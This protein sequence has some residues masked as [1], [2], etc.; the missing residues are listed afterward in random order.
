MVTD[1]FSKSSLDL[2]GKVTLSQPTSLDWGPD[3][4]LYVTEVTGS[5][6]VLTVAFGDVDPNDGEN[7][8]SFYVTEAETLSQ[9]KDI[10]N[11][12]DDG[13]PNTGNNRQVTG[14]SVVQQ[15]AADGTPVIIDGKPAVSVYVTS[16][17]SRMGAGGDG[18]DSGLD[19][20]S[21][22]IT[23]IDQ[24]ETGWE[25]IDLVRGLARS[26]ENH[27]LNGLEVVQEVDENGNLVS[28]RMIV[29]SGGNA[30]SGAPSNNFAGQ[31]ETAYSAAILEVDLDQ[32]NGMPVLT[33][34]SSGRQY[35]YD[36]PTLDD[37]TRP[38]NP[39]EN[40]PFGGNDSLNA[41][42]IDP[43]GPVQIY[44]A[45]YRNSYDVEVTE[46]GRVWTYDNGANDS[47]GGR[48][49]GEAGDDGGNQDFAQLANYIA[50]NL[51]NGDI[52]TGDP[53]N[54]E[55]WSPKN[56]DQFHEIT[57][58]DDLSGRE[59]S[60][61]QGGAQTYQWQDPDSGETL[62]LVYGGHPNPTRASG[63]QSGML[64]TPKDGVEDAYLLLS[65][66]VDP[67]TGTSDFDD[68]F[69]WMEQVEIDY[70]TVDTG[71]LTSRLIGVTPGEHY[72]ITD[73]GNAYLTSNY[74]EQPTEINGE[75][76]LGDSGMPIDFHE[77]VATL[78]PI[79]G[80]Y[81]EG[82]YTDGA[83]DSGKGSINGLTEYT[84]TILDDPDSGVKMSGAILA[85]VLNQGSLVAMGRDENGVMQTSVGGS[86]QTL[87]D[88]RTIIDVNGAPLGLTSI[89]D[90]L[91][92]HGGE[93]AF[94]GSI[95]TTVFKQNGPFIEILQPNNGAVPLAGSEAS[96]P[97]DQDMDGI[98]HI[99]D[100]FEF[101]EDNGFDLAAGERVF[102][103]FQPTGSPY[104]G[105]ILDTG[106]MGAALDGM[107]PNR[108]A[109]TAEEGFSEDQQEDG[110]YDLGGNIIP[111]GNAPI[112]QIKKVVGGSVVGTG[113]TARDAMHVGIK[114]A[115][116]VERLVMSSK[117]K[118]WVPSVT[119]GIKQG[120]LTGIMLGDGTQANFLRFMFGA[121]MVNGSL[122]PGFE[123]GYELDDANYTTLATVGVP[124]LN[125]TDVSLLDLNLE[126]DIENGFAVKASYQLDTQSQATELDLGGFSL[127]PGVL[128]DILT[129]NHTITD[130][131]ITV[132]SGA[133]V[134][135]LAETTPEDAASEDGLSGVDFFN[136]N[137]EAIGNEI[138]ATTGEEVGAE[139]TDGIDTILYTGTDTNLAPLDQSVENFDGSG[140]SADFHVTGHGGDNIFIAG[141]G[142][143]TFTGG[144]GADSIRG[145]FE[146]IDGS[147]ITDF[148]QDDHLLI[149]ESFLSANDVSYSSSGGALILTFTDSNTGE[150][151]SVSFTGPQF[152][153]F[154]PNEGPSVF[155][156]EQT[157]FGTQVT[158]SLETVVYRVNAGGGTVAAL[159][160]DLDW[161]GDTNS[162][163]AYLQG[164][165]T[166]TYSDSLTDE[167]T[168][169]DLTQFD[170]DVVPW[171]VFAQERY[172]GS[173]AEP[174]IEYAF[175]VIAGET[176]SVTLYYTENWSGIFN[177]TG[178]RIFDVEVE[179][180]VPGVFND[181]NPLQEAKDI[182]GPD[183]TNAELL[184]FGL[185]RTY[186]FTA[187]DDTLNLA[188]N[189]GDQNPKINAIEINQI[190]AD[191]GV[192]DSESPVVQSITV[193]DPL[194]NDSPILATVVI[195]DNVEVDIGTVEGDELIITGIEPAT[196]SLSSIVVSNGGKTATVQYQ[197]TP[198]SD[199][200]AWESGTYSVGVAE[201][202]YLD[203]SGNGVAAFETDFTIGDEGGIATLFELDFETAGEPLDEGGFDDVLGGVNDGSVVTTIE[204][205]DLVVNTSDG[206][207]I[208][209][210]SANDFVKFVDLSD[211]SLNELTISSRF[212]NGFPAALTD[213][214]LSP[215]TIPNYAQQGIVFGLGSQG[216]N[217]LVKLVLSGNSGNIVQIWSNPD[218][219]GGIDT[220]YALG[221]MLNDTSL[222]LQDIAEVE[223]SMVIDKAAGT[224]TPIV[225]LYADS[226]AVLG[227]LRATA[228]PGFVTAQAETLPTPVLDNLLDAAANTAVGVTSNDFG[229]LDSFEARWADLRVTSP[230]GASEDAT[231][232]GIDDAP[233]V[234]ESGDSG[235]TTLAFAL[236]A[237]NTVDTTLDILYSVDGGTTQTQAVAFSGNVGMLAIEVP[238]DDV[239][240]GPDT[241]EVSLVGVND[242]QY[243]I[244]P[245]ATTASGTVAEDDAP[246]SDVIGESGVTSLTQAS[247]GDWTSV[248]FS[249]ALVNPAVVMGPLTTNDGE[250]ATVRVRNVTDS[251][252]EF[253]IDEWDYLDGVHGQETISWLAINSGTHTLPNGQTIAA[254]KGAADGTATAFTYGTAFAEAPVVLAQATSTNG[255]ASVT[256]RIDGVTAS[257]FNLRLQHEEGASSAPASEAVDW[258]AVSA[259]GG[260]AGGLLA[261]RTGDQ[262]THQD[263]AIDFGGSFAELAFFA[264]MQTFDGPDSATVRAR[265]IGAEGAT[266]FVEEEQSADSELTH[267][268]EDVG[269]VG[270]NA[271]VITGSEGVSTPTLIGIDDAPTVTESGDSGTTTLAFALTAEDTVDATLD[272]LYSVDGGA[273]QTQAVTFS[274]NVGTLAIEVPNDDVDNGP[275]TVEVSLVGVNDD[276]YAIDPAAT[277]ASGTVAEDDAPASDVIGESGVT[278]LTQASSGDWTSVTFSEALVNPAVVMGPLTTNDG[279]PATV[280]VRNVTDS[281]FEF[282]I[283]EWDYLDGVHGQETISWLAINS[284]THTL[285]SGQTIAAGKGAADGTATAF[286]Y[287]TAFAEAPVVLAQ[288]TSTNGSAA[289][290]DRID[291]VTT[292]GFNLRLQHEE[293]ASSA[294]VSEAVDWIA[295]SEGG[296]TAGGLLAGRTGDQVTHQD[297]AIDFGGS[298]AEL[299]FF[300]DMQTFDGP[301]SAT[302]RARAIG[303]EGATIFVE[304]EQSAD[305]ELTHTHEDVGYVGLNAGVITGSEG[306]STPTLIGIDD[307][308]TVTESGD[309]GTT[310]L[311]FALTAEDTVDATLDIVY[312]VD[313]GAT[314]QTQV[315]AFSGNVGT[316]QVNV[317]NDDIDNGPD[318]V[319]VTLVGINDVQYDSDPAADT[320]SGSVSED[321]GPAPLTAEQVFAG[322][323]LEE[324]ETYDASMIGSA[325][326]TIMP[327]N[328]NVQ[329][330]NFGNDAF[331]VTN[332]GDKKIAAV[333]FDV[334]S[335]LYGDS[336]FDPDGKG[337]DT[338]FKAWDINTDGGTG[339]IS[340][341]EYEHYFLP[342]ADPNPTD[343]NTNG[344]YRGALVKF[345]A[346]ADGGF[347]QGETVG[348]SGDMDPNSIAGMEKNGTLGVDTDSEPD[349]DV[350]GVSGAELTGSR[351]YVQFTDGSIASAQLMGDG[352]QAGSQALVSE[353]S[354]NLVASLTVNGV[355]PGGVGNYANEVP[356][357]QVSGEPGAWVR[358]VMTKGHQPVANTNGSLAEIVDWRL[359]GES[360]A[361][362]NAA[363]FQFVDVQLDGNGTADVSGQFTYDSF[364]NGTESFE[365]DDTLPLGF[366]AA[367][368]EDPNLASG[369]VALG[370]VTQPI[371]LSHGTG[372]G[373]DPA[374]LIGIDDAPTVTESG[375]SGT[376]TLAFAL[377]AD[378]TVDTTLDI[379]YSVDGGTTQT[380]A[381]A[382]NGNVGTLAIEVPN[383]DVDNGPD[384]VE[385]GLIGVNDDQYDINPNADSASGIVEEDDAS[386][387]EPGVIGESGVVTLT[388]TDA[389]SWTSVSFSE[390]LEDPAVVMGPVTYNGSEQ[391]TVRLRNVTDTGF[392]FQIDEWDSLDGVH[393]EESLG[394]LAI[395]SGVH[396]LA[397][398]QTIAAGKGQGSSTAAEISLGTDF[399]AAPVVLAQTT[400]VNE[401]SAVTHRIDAVDGDSFT[402][403]LQNEEADT[404]GHGLESVDW[405][406]ISEGGTT[407]DGL[408]A[409]RTG[410]QVT[411]SSFDIQFDGS[412]DEVAFFADMQTFD[413]TDPASV[414][415]AAINADGATIFIE[416]EQS[417]DS[418]VNHISEDVGF[419]GLNTGLIT[420]S[421]SMG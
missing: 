178:D 226:G 251:G 271:G 7:I 248:T 334:R 101:S 115:Q 47:W 414:R 254:G 110:L 402:L 342:G 48:P 148:L 205:G 385:V 153:D 26:E 150:T 401:A 383:D 294:P 174:K 298:F 24:T 273:T 105:T 387:S 360:F 347:T 239:D 355:N 241:V 363:E 263:F 21:G 244:D 316:L 6:K 376:T 219:S 309:S 93:T 79:E 317:V 374:T 211:E 335:A 372:G 171:Q 116:D 301:D 22:V 300:A 86:G 1:N 182:L 212:T 299:A 117:I 321:D 420:A 9:V 151:S 112:F 127:P 68:V 84:S 130:G 373:S 63:G 201:G 253:Q 269:Y 368:I 331:Q 123:V 57:R 404:S 11:F 419:V 142:N 391:V 60:A 210:N 256:D 377:T 305:S 213:Q 64:F 18:A 346:T 375:D 319:E 189:H 42:K 325:L 149:L 83:L 267:T 337:G 104:P 362:N 255:S 283:D 326:V 158:Y 85:A 214:G 307:A 359:S 365:G 396:T 270:L 350:G 279:E 51:N 80:D 378:N 358:V 234:T 223:M 162:D 82:G 304:E 274:G 25:A 242:D 172:D 49:I 15:Y 52:N 16:S 259:G 5:V 177:Y 235:T 291:G 390:P 73:A 324:S 395:N 421:E 249:E 345:S 19:T 215:D 181:I 264:D 236:T 29:A 228:T 186:T 318:T 296:G 126:V 392:E 384:T 268:H 408:L 258:I 332:T 221:D 208:N 147:V 308:P 292:S 58:S 20:N 245:A 41:G 81:R 323:D 175:P 134:G 30:N 200:N 166:Q 199:T 240:N 69:D 190:G 3:G 107:T 412:F 132:P 165:T 59:L 261:G 257:G 87:A 131:G 366:M 34:T 70:D 53:I 33:D 188:F 410:D 161:E 315:V 146:T 333:F 322:A 125:T 43:D 76:V 243:A 198:P 209:G 8:N 14:I 229:V 139:G 284:G 187:N 290:T 310:T 415:A 56:Y 233:T 405:I 336:V 416:E 50:T 71:D 32:L 195:N 329:S 343:P 288:A 293:G 218:A 145:T 193:E 217:E 163:F 406:A 370:P 168:E 144:G 397:N 196:V 44:S 349:W 35:I 272:I 74:D 203:T 31:Q 237:E 252:F 100:P 287:G 120:Q 250:P 62:T 265:A 220:P 13:S 361:A 206:D 289:V 216:E 382:F 297:F 36:V 97:T 108:D 28:E 357:V 328:E 173:A 98:D 311:A 23:R 156:F 141:S 320:A 137:V 78:N 280:R 61:G 398:G 413:G 170:A 266:I 65:N 128:Q 140:S 94:Q 400:S 157:P 344:G 338:A 202:S 225:T 327:G 403:R 37:P 286:T 312:S 204:G 39:D 411:S 191:S 238:N 114:P 247:S 88:D 295:V 136:L 276:Q 354:Q 176:Y 231:L 207:I 367:V 339:A 278:S 353:A 133:A 340:P 409:G 111:G 169:I 55:N 388:Q 313:G 371:Y 381:V 285:P 99:H 96:D 154:D 393:I 159:D 124:D 303:A 95:W 227:G 17:D 90:D 75:T 356:T 121:V 152:E 180:A 122:M 222:G 230:D 194:D 341:S 135:F 394:W 40:D 314:T 12:N 89:G 103:D 179:G 184:G 302:V 102:L 275:D 262:V 224:V 10:P 389:D 160:G 143:N 399:G 109:K 45:G 380:Q 417:A 67:D 348:F 77:V 118:N 183:A 129:G 46:D 282:Q 407:L 379:L 164:N 306:V 246:A 27:A 106:L 54:L 91:G 277:T 352:S 418:E 281:G 330:S 232:I 192:P 2:N 386:A 72:Y 66:V 167:E 260:T 351:V 113:N 364:L 185:S 138:E 155:E 4:R 119:G 92:P 38:G 197:L 369:G